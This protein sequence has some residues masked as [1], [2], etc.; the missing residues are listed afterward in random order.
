M[1]DE[2]ASDYPYTPNFDRYP[3]RKTFQ[4]DSDVAQWVGSE[5]SA[6]GRLAN[7]QNN[8]A[9]ASVRANIGLLTQIRSGAPFPQAVLNSY[10]ASDS[11]LGRIV[12]NAADPNVGS[13]AF[14]MATG[15][16][17]N[18]NVTDTTVAAR[19]LASVYQIV[20]GL[21]ENEDEISAL[22]K[23]LAQAASDV[24]RLRAENEMEV[25]RIKQLAAGAEKDWA[26]R[27]EGYEEKA[28]LGAPTD[29]WRRRSERHD[30][31]AVRTRRQWSSALWI[32]GVSFVLSVALGFS[33]LGDLAFPVKPGDIVSEVSSLAR[34]ILVITTLL[35]L[36]V[37]WLRQKLRDLRAHEHLGEDAAERVTMI[38]TY[39]A[40]K[41]AGLQDK[42]LALV[43]TALYRPATTGLIDDSGPNLPIEILLKGAGAF[44]AKSE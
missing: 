43:L 32:V 7:N 20:G 35:A 19:A 16:Q 30:K 41:G 13:I 27:L 38:E 14:A 34:R 23:E 24:S 36:A 39:A 29:Y 2:A 40:L 1:G 25:G 17:T 26:T 12:L 8:N 42:D 22:R 33:G 9:P 3:I 15:S 18:W 10:C 37:W 5:R 6:W 31:L 44:A 11:T 21:M 4:S 28:R